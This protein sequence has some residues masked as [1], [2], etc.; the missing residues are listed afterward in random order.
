MEISE[1]N[2]LPAFT[3]VTPSFNQGDFLE[4]TIQSVLAQNYPNLEYVVMDGGSTDRSVEI[5]R[6]Y[7]SHL[8][9][10]ESHK[11]SGHVDATYRG[12]EWGRGEL[13]GWVSSDDLLLPGCL[14]KVG[15]YFA[16]HPEIVC[17]IGGAVIIDQD[18]RPLRSRS[19]TALCNLGNRMTFDKL[20]FK[21]CSFNQPAS[22]WRRSA[23]ES[24]GGFDRRLKFSHD[25]DMYFRLAQQ[26]PFGQI[27]DWLACFR[28][29]STSKTS[30]LQAL[31]AAENELLWRK[32]GRYD[33]GFLKRAA[34]AALYAV[35]DRARWAA[36]RLELASGMRRCPDPRAARDRQHQP[37]AACFHHR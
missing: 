5:I 13:L 30:T 11:D 2:S 6:K 8:H 28:L 21:H 18:S 7:E 9:H 14:H 31:C 3:I 37:D 29:H 16:A 27:K 1:S 34:L 20:L 35:E 33:A 32:Y 4:E 10:W 19:G 25:Y 36:L 24:G 17:V 22:F 26:G 15:R 12:F 23:F